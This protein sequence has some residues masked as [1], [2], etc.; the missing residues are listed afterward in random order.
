MI[1]YFLKL[2]RYNHWA[3]ELILNMVSK[4]NLR[5]PEITKLLSHILN[6][7]MVWYSRVSAEKKY[8]RK[9]WEVYEWEELHPLFKESSNL[10]VKYLSET[11][12]EKLK[13]EVPYK[14]SLG[15]PFSNVAEDILA[16]VINHGTYHRGQIAKLLRQ[17]NIDPPGTD[18]VTFVRSL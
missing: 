16:H 2:F 9:V 10:W 14:T 1:S 6:A 12:P 3:N 13:E 11:D 7:Q 15:D 17:K 8:E 5:D 18:Y 4:A